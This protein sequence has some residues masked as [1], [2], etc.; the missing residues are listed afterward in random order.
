MIQW[1]HEDIAQ[2]RMRPLE[3]RY[4]IIFIDCIHVKV[5]RDTV[6]NEAYM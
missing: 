2:W 5:R 1:M 6:Q 3:R 4:P